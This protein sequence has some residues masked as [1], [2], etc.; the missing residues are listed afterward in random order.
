MKARQEFLDTL[1]DAERHQVSHCSSPKELLKAIQEFK[2]SDKSGAMAKIRTFLDVL[3][4]YFTAVGMIAQANPYASIAW[5]SVLMLFHVRQFR[6]SSIVY[7]LK[8]FS[9]PKIP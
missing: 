1:P 6:A 5:G 4:P 2:M 9:S 8:T 7:F 3:G